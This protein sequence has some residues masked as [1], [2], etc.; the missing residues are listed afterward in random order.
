MKLETPHWAMMTMDPSS[1]TAED[2]R[3][4]VLLA[5]AAPATNSSREND[6][7][8]FPFLVDLPDDVSRR[9]RP[10]RLQP[11]STSSHAAPFATGGST[12]TSSSRHTQQLE[13]RS[14][15]EADQEESSA[16][17]TNV[18]SR[19]VSSLAL[20]PPPTTSSFSV[21]SS[22]AP[23]QRFRLQK[24]SIRQQHQTDDVDNG[25]TGFMMTATWRHDDN[26]D[27]GAAAFGWF[28]PQ[29]LLATD[30]ASTIVATPSSSSVAGNHEL[31][32]SSS[33]CLPSIG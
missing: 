27:D 25:L 17:P 2:Q 23:L 29:E 21:S 18:L 7:D 28:R 22:S 5:H 6:E 1:A 24:R 16:V 11:R 14:P 15:A 10:P 30:E 13:P 20:S 8:G 26:G 32:P 4:P 31:C 19:N 12:S 3:P 33:L 9:V